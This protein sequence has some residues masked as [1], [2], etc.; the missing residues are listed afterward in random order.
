MSDDLN[1]AI[2]DLER[3]ETKIERLRAALKQALR[4]WSMYAEMVEGS[5][6][7]FALE[8]EKSAEGDMYRAAVAL[9]NEE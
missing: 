2:D 6:R 3:A 9:A 5:D 7:D 8:T 1:G 4:Q